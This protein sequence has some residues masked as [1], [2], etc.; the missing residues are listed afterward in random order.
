MLFENA[1]D[2]KGRGMSV[3]IRREV[4]NADL[5]MS[6]DLAAPERGRRW[7]TS[8]DHPSAGRTKLVFRIVQDERASMRRHGGF[9]RA[10]LQ[11]DPRAICR[12]TLP[13]A[14]IG[15]RKH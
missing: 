6:I 10:Q 2:Q 13:I 12:K 15:A 8:V 5:I 11:S 7:R 4:G 14:A 1:G 3:E 9:S